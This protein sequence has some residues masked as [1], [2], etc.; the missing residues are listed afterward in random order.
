V[1]D[2]YLDRDW[3]LALGLD[4]AD[5]D[6]LLRDSP[7]P[8]HCGRPL[9]VADRLQDLLQMLHEDSSGLEPGGSLS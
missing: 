1:S 6:R 8:G 7:L 3:L 4:K 9:V 2:D 5:V